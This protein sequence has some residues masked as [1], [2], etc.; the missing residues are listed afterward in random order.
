[1]NFGNKLKLLRKSMNLSQDK[2]SKLSGIP[3]STISQYELNLFEPS[4]SNLK[5]ISKVFNISLDQLCDTSISKNNEYLL[6]TISKDFNNIHKQNLI[7]IKSKSELYEKQI[8]QNSILLI[9]NTDPNSIIFGDI[10]YIVI[11]NIFFLYAVYP[12]NSKFLL[13]NANI[14]PKK[15]EFTSSDLEK[16]LIGVVKKVINDV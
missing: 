7:L 16:C 11:D 3:R 13:I 2:L 10:V 14:S 8:T 6:D 15:H 9:E 1:M 5:T 4:L 12:Y